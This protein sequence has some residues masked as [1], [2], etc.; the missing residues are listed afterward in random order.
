MK[1]DE[2]NSP[3]TTHEIKF[4]KDIGEYDNIMASIEFIEAMKKLP[5][6]LSKFLDR[7]NDE[8]PKDPKKASAV[9]A[10]ISQNDPEFFEQILAYSTVLTDLKPEEKKIERVSIKQE[11]EQERAEAYEILMKKIKSI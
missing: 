4:L 9:L 7:L 1:F 10:K 6:D 11:Q 2:K 8:I 3:F 5:K